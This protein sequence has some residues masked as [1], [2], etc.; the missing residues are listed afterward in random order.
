MTF[1]THVVEHREAVRS[2]GAEVPERQLVIQG[3]LA[4]RHRLFE[5]G[6]ALPV[7]SPE[8][9]VEHG[10][11]A[12]VVDPVLVVLET[13]AYV[14]GHLGR[15]ARH[16]LRYGS[17]RGRGQP[18][19][20]LHGLRSERSRVLGD[21]GEADRVARD[22]V[23]VVG[24][25]LHDLVDEPPRESAVGAGTH[26]GVD[27]GAASDGREP[28]IHHHQSRAPSPCGGDVLGHVGMRI[29]WV[30]APQD[31][32]ASVLEVGHRPRSVDQLVAHVAP[33]V[34]HG[35]VGE[36][37]GAPEGVS[38]AARDGLLLAEA[39]GLA[40]PHADAARAVM[41]SDRGE[42][43]GDLVERLRERDLLPALVGPLEG[44]EDTVWVID[45]VHG[46]PG[47]RAQAAPVPQMVLVAEDV[48]DAAVLEMDVDTAAV[49]AHPAERP[50]DLRSL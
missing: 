25:R 43:S 44:R 42:T 32:A 26:G 16:R 3:E 18:R 10:D 5:Q 33:D 47:L 28:R 49:V 38:E 39:D 6:A 15:G 27:V 11:G 2:E 50:L 24:A 1:L 45:H 34:A 40:L 7:Q 17:D 23:L 37:V 35:V 12:D 13:V 48:D 22:E 31:D 9:P 29:G 4:Q 30:R 36:V 8:Q 41:V 20:L 19:L 21:L 46:R 14:R